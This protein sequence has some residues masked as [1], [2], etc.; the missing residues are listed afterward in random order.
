MPI[1]PLMIEHRVIERMIGLVREEALRLGSSK[2]PDA[3]FIDSAVDFIR[4]YADETHHG[5]EERILFRELGKKGLSPGFRAEMEGLI[6][7]HRVGRRATSELVD[8]CDRYFR[9]D[10]GA[11][12]AIIDKMLF[13]AEFYPRHIKKED[14][15]FFIPAM[16]YFTPDEQKTMLEEG[17]AFDRRMIH[18]KY[19][20][21]VGEWEGRRGVPPPKHLPNWEDF[22]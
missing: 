8:A 3:A 17:R 9:G 6:A 1:G 7:D 19:D 22:M 21:L 14:E 15:H 2:K 16:K 4:T 5:K 12:G 20:V 11:L 13:L 10:D 18:R